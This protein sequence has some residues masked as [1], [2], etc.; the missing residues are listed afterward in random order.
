MTNNSQ[1][2]LIHKE[3][4]QV[5]E[6]R[7]HK[8]DFFGKSALK[9]CIIKDEVKLEEQKELDICS[10]HMDNQKEDMLIKIISPKNSNG[11]TNN[12]CSSSNNNTNSNVKN[13][14][15]ESQLAAIGS[16]RL[17]EKSQTENTQPSPIN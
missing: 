5:D 10:E 16:K 4:G 6:V 9:N 11:N 8:R 3:E 13:A 12:N 15:S 7:N 14:S 1:D 2:D 17:S